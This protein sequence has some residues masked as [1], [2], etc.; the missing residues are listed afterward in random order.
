ME[1]LFTVTIEHLERPKWDREFRETYRLSAEGLTWPEEASYR[2]FARA[3]PM[4]T[5]MCLHLTAHDMLEE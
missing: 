3:V 2:N 4:P 1:D 5:H